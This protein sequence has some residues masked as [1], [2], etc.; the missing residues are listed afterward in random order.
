MFVRGIL[1]VA[2][3]G[4]WSYGFAEERPRTGF[5]TAVLRIYRIRA[6]DS[7]SLVRE[8]EMVVP[9]DRLFVSLASHEVIVFAKPS[10]QQSVADAIAAY[11]KHAL[12]FER[13]DLFSADPRL[14]D[15]IVRSGIDAGSNEDAEPMAK[16]S[17][18]MQVDSTNRVLVWG[19]ASQIEFV[20]QTIDALNQNGSQDKQA[21]APNNRT[22][23][24]AAASK[25][26]ADP[27]RRR[28]RLLAPSGPIRIVPIKGADLLLIRG[29]QS[30][31]ERLFDD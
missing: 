15:K 31:V 25:E 14:V 17:L 28:A 6:V 16:A 2:L 23:K 3:V 26:T 7:D 5:D 18:R 13:I 22:A 11:E 10:V 9:S 21:T 12:L 27:S 29:Q 20:K 19:R 4:C 8:I 1:V 24:A 30:D